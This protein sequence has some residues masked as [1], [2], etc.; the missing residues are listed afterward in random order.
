MVD[1]LGGFAKAEEQERQKLGETATSVSASALSKTTVA[2]AQEVIKLIQPDRG[3]GVVGEP[4][5]DLR[6]LRTSP[7]ILSPLGHDLDIAQ[8]QSRMLI[9]DALWIGF[10]SSAQHRAETIGSDKLK[11]TVDLTPQDRADLNGY[12]ILGLTA[13]EWAESLRRQLEESVNRAL[14]IPLTT[15]F[16]LSGIPLALGEAS[17]AHAQRVGGAVQEAHAAGCQAAL[18]AISAALTGAT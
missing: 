18:R 14:A 11:I 17:N 7:R 16:D 6:Q 12:P 1:A 8:G 9:A 2:A 15:G 3:R 5:A 13:F 4:A 10:R